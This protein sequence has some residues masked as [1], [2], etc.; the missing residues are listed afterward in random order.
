M[1]EI[2][3]GSTSHSFFIELLDSTTG[4]P[5][6][7]IV[8][9]DVTASYVRTREARTE[10][11]PATLASADAAWSSGGFIL[12]DDTNQPGIYR[13]DVPNAAFADGVEEVVVTIKATGC[14]SQSRW[15]ALVNSNNQ[16][17]IADQVWDENVASHGTTDTTG[18]ILA[19]SAS[20]AFVASQVGA[21]GSLIGI[22]GSGLTNINLPNQTMDIVGNITGN[23]SG[24]VGSVTG[25][26]GGIAGTLT[27]LDAIW[28]K[29]KKYFQLAL[30]S[31]A[32]ITTDNATELTEI[33]ASGG[34]GAGDYAATT[35]SQEALRDSYTGGDTLVVAPIVAQLPTDT[36]TSSGTTQAFQ[37]T[38]LPSGPIVVVDADLDPINLTGADLKMVCV[39]NSVPGTT[40]TLT[41]EDSELV[42]GG[43]GNN[44]ITVDYLALLA[45]TYK[46]HLYYQ[47]SGETDWIKCAYGFWAIQE[48]PDPR[49]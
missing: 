8:Y 21:I 4:L 49:S 24:S 6:T 18:Q 25:N 29:I 41:S 37:Y 20:M 9:T 2:F 28:S 42:L 34:S 13:F 3:K 31:D 11:T 32:A 7:G 22:G 47:P 5:K 15:F 43:A 46:W 19:D 40:F 1:T 12:V 48:G 16:V 27:T 14:R 26:V 35:D 23:L 44:E 45:G 17:A 30:R 39:L 38:P 33:N 10:I 36:I